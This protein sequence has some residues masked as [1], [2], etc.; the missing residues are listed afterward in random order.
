MVVFDHYLKKY[1]HNLIQTWCVHLLGEW[2]ELIRFWATLAKFWLSGGRTR[3][4]NGGFR[5]LSEKVFTQSYSNLVCALI[6]GVLRIDCFRA[7]LA[8]LWPFSGHKIT[9]NGGFLPLSEKVPLCGI[10][11]MITVSTHTH[12]VRTGLEGFPRMIP[13]FAA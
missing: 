11:I 4:E 7:M 2:S 12:G 6:W 8:K 13:F 3:T 9:E 5:P 10:I 1:S